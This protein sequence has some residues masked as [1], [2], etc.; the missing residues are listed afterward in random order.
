MFFKK[1]QKSFGKVL[2]AFDQ[3]TFLSQQKW[4]DKN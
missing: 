1:N 2:R 4:L 3:P